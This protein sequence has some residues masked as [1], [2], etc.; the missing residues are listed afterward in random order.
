VV[1][2]LRAVASARRSGGAIH[3]VRSYSDTIS[4]TLARNDRDD[5]PRVAEDRDRAGR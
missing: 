2:T 3:L 5:R 1:I 4:S